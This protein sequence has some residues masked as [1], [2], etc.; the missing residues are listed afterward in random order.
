VQSDLTDGESPD[1]VAMDFHADFSN[2]AEADRKVKEIAGLL[3]KVRSE[4]RIADYNGNTFSELLQKEKVAI[5]ASKVGRNDPCPCG[6]GLKY[7][8]CCGRNG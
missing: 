7:K 1:D 8:K 6:S 5:A 3:W 2:A 4:M